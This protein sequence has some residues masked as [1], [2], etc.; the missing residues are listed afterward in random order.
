MKEFDDYQDF[1]DTT[2]AYPDI[3]NNVIY[4]ALGLAE[5]AGEVAGKIKK[6][7]RDDGGILTEDR[8]IALLKELGDVLWYVA[9]LARELGVP[10]SQVAELNRLKL[11]SRRAR[12]RIGGSGDER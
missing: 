4:P 6:A 5:E 7:I 3:G 11:K 2:A 9:R 12:N 8:T 1:T 10:F